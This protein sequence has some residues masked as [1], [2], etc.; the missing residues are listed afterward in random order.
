MPRRGED[1]AQAQG[2]HRARR[3]RAGAVHVAGQRSRPGRDLGRDP[4]RRPG[5]AGRGRRGRAGVDAAV[6]PDAAPSARARRRQAHAAA[7]RRPHL[8]AQRDVQ[9]AARRA[10]A[11]DRLHHPRVR[12]ARRR[13][14]AGRRLRARFPRAAA[15]LVAAREAIRPGGRDRLVL[16]TLALANWLLDL[17]CLAAVCAAAGIGLGFHTVLLGYVAAKTAMTVAVVPGGLGVTEVGMAATLVAAGVAGGPAAA[18]VALYRLISYWAV[19]VAG[20]AAWLALRHRP[21][22]AG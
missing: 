3:D 6:R 4:G 2:G 12:Q 13:E 14:T 18:V 17:A 8:R 15:Q 20:W 22:T 16:I 9:L 1:G 21:R 19:L 7:R 11:V 10:A 5:L